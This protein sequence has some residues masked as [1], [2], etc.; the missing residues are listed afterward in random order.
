MLAERD[1]LRRERDELRGQLR[2]VS[3]F[4]LDE[5]GLLDGFTP[6]DAWR[7]YGLVESDLALHARRAA[8]T[9]RRAARGARG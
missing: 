6:E 9:G 3:V 7:R 2:L 1:A 5:L 8:R 4:A